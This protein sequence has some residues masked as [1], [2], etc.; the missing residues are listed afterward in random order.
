MARRR[1]TSSA[2]EGFNSRLQAVLQAA[3]LSYKLA[4]LD[5]DNERR[6]H[7]QMTAGTSTARPPKLPVE[8][9]WARHIYHLFVVRTKDREG[10]S[11][12]LK[13]RSIGT[14][15]HYPTPIHLRRSTSASAT[16]RAL[17]GGGES[18]ERELSLPMYPTMRDEEVV[19]VSGAVKAFYTR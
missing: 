9:P 17:P 3:I 14:L 1:S 8:K 19:A 6:R 10:L 18:R 16:R 2:V 11:G 4:R 12:Y 13:S 5:A 15:V 7:R